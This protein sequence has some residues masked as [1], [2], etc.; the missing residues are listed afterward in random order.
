MVQMIYEIDSFSQNFIKI[1]LTLSLF[2]SYIC[3]RELWPWSIHNLNIIY[4]TPSS[5]G[6]IQK[7]GHLG[8]YI[9]WSIIMWSEF[10][11]WD[12]YMKK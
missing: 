4:F 11:S 9:V 12:I 2:L 5:D 6:S 3:S 7:Y 8:I 10:R 1:P